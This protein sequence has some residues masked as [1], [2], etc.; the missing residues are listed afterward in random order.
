MCTKRQEYG[1]TE[2]T[3]GKS[4][5]KEG[6]IDGKAAE[7]NKKNRT[8]KREETEREDMHEE[9]RSAWRQGRRRRE[10]KGDPGRNK[11]QG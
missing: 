11:F 4:R 2:G 1:A 10:M 9:T 6:K 8:A 5:R 7:D 3:K